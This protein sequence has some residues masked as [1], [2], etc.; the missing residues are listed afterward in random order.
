MPTP[1]NAPARRF[2]DAMAASSRKGSGMGTPSLKLNTY[3]W[4]LPEKWYQVARTLGKSPKKSSK[5]DR[6]LPN[7]KGAVPLGRTIADAWKEISYKPA[8]INSNCDW[9]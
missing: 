3:R 9:P 5:I 8:D 7:L 2:G 1:K 6:T 4:K